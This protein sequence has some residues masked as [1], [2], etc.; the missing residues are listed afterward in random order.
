MK[1]KVMSDYQSCPLWDLGPDGPRNLDPSELPLSADL[2]RSLDEWARR[3]DATLVI[4]DPA[5]SGFTD[6]LEEQAFDEEGLQ[7]AT[8]LKAELGGESTVEY[9]EQRTGKVIDL[10]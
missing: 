10:T 6:P 3:F 7:L 1:I 2:K 5:R 4:D 8:R 9:F